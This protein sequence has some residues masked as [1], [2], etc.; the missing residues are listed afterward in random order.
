MSQMADKGPAEEVQRW[1][2]KRRANLVSQSAQWCDGN[3]SGYCG[4]GGEDKTI[5]APDRGT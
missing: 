5:G 4:V 1:T 2:A 3:G